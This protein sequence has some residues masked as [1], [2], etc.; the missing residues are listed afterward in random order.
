MTDQ[1]PIPK[2]VAT[3]GLDTAAARQL[4]GWMAAQGVCFFP[5]AALTGSREHARQRFGHAVVPLVLQ[6]DADEPVLACRA[7][8]AVCECCEEPKPDGE[9][10][11]I[12]DVDVPHDLIC[13]DCRAM[14]GHGREAF[15]W[16]QYCGGCERGCRHPRTAQSLIDGKPVVTYCERCKQ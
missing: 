1:Q 9:V 8:C 13:E 10:Y 11:P 14:C 15:A 2:L 4:M 16:P 5:V 12:F 6:P 7:C 3:I